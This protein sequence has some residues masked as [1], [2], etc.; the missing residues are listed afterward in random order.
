[1]A[2]PLVGRRVYIAGLASK[3]ELNGKQ[4]FAVS[5][6]DDN[7]R[8]NVSIDGHTDVMALKPVNVLPVEGAGAG[9]GG[10]GDSSDGSGGGVSEALSRIDP[11]H[12]AAGT[13]AALVFL[14]GFSLLNAVLLCGVGFLAHS[15]A[16]REG[17]L[18]PAAR[19]ITRRLSELLLRLSGHSLTQAQIVVLVAAVAFLV[20]KFWL[21]DTGGGGSGFSGSGYESSRSR[22]R[23]HQGYDQR[24]YDS[25][26][27]DFSS[28]GSGWGAG[29]DL[30][31]MISAAMLAMMVWQL[32]GGRGGEG[33]SVGELI[34]RVQNMDFWQMMMFANLLQSVLGGGRRGGYGHG[35]GRGFGRR[36]HY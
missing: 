33:W 21:S 7:G 3:P 24:G 36:M 4:G 11:K 16:R 23:T 5:F 30:S 15:A 19:A 10:G 14:L 34:R 26:S 29:W 2:A 27:Y 20:W 6:N 12:V 9:A 17:G 35:Y 28:Y 31:F 8:Y 22:R 13:C 25:G 32:G 18:V 1:M